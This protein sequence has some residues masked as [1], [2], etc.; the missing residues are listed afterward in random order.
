MYEIYNVD[1]KKIIRDLFYFTQVE[2]QKK[3]YTTLISVFG[4]RKKDKYPILIGNSHQN[5]ASWRGERAVA[6]DILNQAF[7]YRW[8]DKE[9][10]YNLKNKNLQ[11]HKM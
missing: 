1:K 9:I 4:I 8:A 6:N 5:M 10:H 3:G 2:S 7:G 11:V